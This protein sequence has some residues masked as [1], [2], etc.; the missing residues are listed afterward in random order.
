MRER[1][2]KNKNKNKENKEKGNKENKC[3]DDKWQRR[4]V[5]GSFP[6]F[7]QFGYENQK[8]ERGKEK[9]EKCEEENR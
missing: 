5:V 1:K 2:K 3:E 9:R 4:K 8:R 7:D 6:Q